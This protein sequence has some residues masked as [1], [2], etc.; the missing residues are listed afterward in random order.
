MI[1]HIAN[2]Y[3]ELRAA[4]SGPGSDYTEICDSIDSTTDFNEHVTNIVLMAMESKQLTVGIL[5]KI[6][7]FDAHRGNGYGRSMFDKFMS[8]ISSST[9]VDLIFA[10]VDNRQRPGFSLQDFYAKAGFEPVL[11]SCGD[12]LMVNKGYAKEF[13][14]IIFQH[15]PLGVLRSIAD[16]SSMDL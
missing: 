4:L 10:R 2:E 9:H 3:G 11:K 15:C 5:T 8:E 12:L 14:D 13:K 1:L 7:V 16:E 6:E